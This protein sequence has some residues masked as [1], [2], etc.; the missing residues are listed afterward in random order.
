LVGTHTFNLR[1]YDSI[2]QPYESTDLPV[3][4]VVYDPCLAATIS[5]TDPTL[6]GA[7]FYDY[8]LS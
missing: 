8:T 5:W 1:A 4:L 3:T 7:A 2:V 6:D